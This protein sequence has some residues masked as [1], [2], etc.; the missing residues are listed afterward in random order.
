MPVLDEFGLALISVREDGDEGLAKGMELLYSNFLSTLK[1]VGLSEIKTEGR[2]DPYIHEIMMT[3]EAKG[4]KP[5]TILKV[6]KKGY[7]LGDVLLRPAS[8]IVAREE[9]E[10]DDVKNEK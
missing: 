8:V 5:G 2:F 6:M 3:E 10:K 7:M 4:K 1:K 9:E